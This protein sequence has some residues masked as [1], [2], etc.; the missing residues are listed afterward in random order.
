MEP[1]IRLK[2]KTVKSRP[3]L[4]LKVGYLTK[5]ESPRCPSFLSFHYF[6]SFVLSFFLSFA[7]SRFYLFIR[8]TQRERQRHRQRKKQAPC[9]EPDMGLDP[10][11]P[12]SRPG[13]KAVLNR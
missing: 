12:G 2:F 4:I 8:D 11:S 1:N 10:E 3:E 6:G 5:D 7:L 13:L 9:R